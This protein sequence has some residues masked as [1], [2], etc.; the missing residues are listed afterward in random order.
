MKFEVGEKVL[1][2]SNMR[3]FGRKIPPTINDE[4][5]NSIMKVGTVVEEG[6]PYRY[7]ANY[8]TTYI[9]EVDGN[10]WYFIE[11][12]LEKTDSKIPMKNIY[13]MKGDEQL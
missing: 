5:L 7:G 2:S 10:R 9:V 8:T 11:D 4:M 1:I 13:T 12:W 3:N 6:F